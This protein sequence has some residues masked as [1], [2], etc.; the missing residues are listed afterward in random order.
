M[1]VMACIDDSTSRVQK[2]YFVS[3]DF[4]L[5]NC[6]H[7]EGGMCFAKIF[8]STMTGRESRHV[9]STDRAWFWSHKPNVEVVGLSWSQ[10][11]Y[12]WSMFLVQVWSGL[13]LLGL[14]WGR[15]GVGMFCFWKQLASCLLIG[16]REGGRRCEGL[17][18]WAGEQADGREQKRVTLVVWLTWNAKYITYWCVYAA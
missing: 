16:S 15:S 13:V 18:H 14:G 10:P 9:H 3:S 1:L 7:Q 17:L 8:S 5:C 6:L 2:A 11:G 12:G 4:L